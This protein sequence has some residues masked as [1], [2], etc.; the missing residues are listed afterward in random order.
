MT[1]PA[2]LRA[3]IE[4]LAATPAD[5]PDVEAAREASV[6]VLGALERGDVRA[7]ERGEDGVW[8]ANAWVKQG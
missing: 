8:R 4:T 1:D 6:A 5:S 7:A 2:A 3:L